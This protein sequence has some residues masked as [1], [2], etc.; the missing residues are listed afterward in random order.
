MRQAS[1]I[2]AQLSLIAACTLC[3]ALVLLTVMMFTGQ[4]PTH[5]NPYNSY[6]LQACA[7]LEGRLDLGQDYPWL[8]LAI[9]DGRYYVS[10]PPFPSYIMLPF[11]A[12]FGSSTPDNIIALAVTLLAVVYACLIYCRLRTDGHGLMWVLFLL[13]G[14]GYL[15]ICFTGYVWFIA[16]NLCLALSLMAIYHALLGQGNVS[17]TC[18]ACAVGCRPMAALYLPILLYMLYRQQ[19]SV[20]PEQSPARIVLRRWYW[21]IG[22][23]VLGGSYMVLNHLRFGSVLE[24]GHNFLPEFTRAEYGQFSLNYIADNL[25]ALLRLP[26]WNGQEDPL[27][28]YSANGMAFWLANPMYF[29]LAAAWAYTLIRSLR[30]KEKQRSAF[31]L[32]ALPLL[33]LLYALILCAH[34]TLGGWHF[35]N[36][37]LLDTLPWLYLGLLCWKPRDDRFDRMNLPLACFGTALNL[38]GTVAAFNHWI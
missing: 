26:Q 32:A 20:Y 31:L 30:H 4:W 19:R 14:T 21:A 13:L 11:A 3:M 37:Y 35:G 2:R 15:F 22:P 10:F 33:S 28:F 29:S 27:T 16:Q 38:L 23:L 17:L 36:R 7:W 5:H 9:V 8:E 6:T 34:R 12:I 1:P 25:C 24:F 18:W